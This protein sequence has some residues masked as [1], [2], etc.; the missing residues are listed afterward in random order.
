[1]KYS[2]RDNIMSEDS[3]IKKQ[4]VR[5]GSY[6]F[7]GFGFSQ[8]IRLISNIILT[9]LLFP[10]LFG[11]MALAQIVIQGVNLFSDLG[12]TKGLIRSKRNNEPDFINTA[13]TI[14]IIRGFVLTIVILILA[15]PISRFYNQK[16]LLY[17]I[18]ILSINSIIQSFSSTSLILLSK[19][20]KQGKLNL[21]ELGSQFIGSIFMISVA[22]FFKNIWSLII[23]VIITSIVKTIWSH[24]ITNTKNYLILEKD[25]ASELLGFGKWILISTSMTFMATQA[26]RIILGKIFTLS[27][28]GIYNVA[29]MFAELPKQLISKISHNLLFPL[30]TKYIHL[31]KNDLKK[32]IKRQRT[33]I[34]YPAAV[35]VAVMFCFG[36][37][38]ITFL[39]DDRYK[40]ASWMLQLLSIGM[41]P[42]L[43][44]SSI[45]NCLFALGKPEYS[46]Y[47]HIS[48]LIYMLVLLPLSYNFFGIPSS[49]IVIALNDIPVYLWINFGLHK[50]KLTIFMQDLLSSLFLIF[51]IILFF[52]FRLLL[53][54]TVPLFS[55]L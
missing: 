35:I 42:L 46:T 33:V 55:I 23:G 19:D 28:L 22:Y 48:K 25:A 2:F 18:P 13:W 10:E 49:I 34:L 44:H 54:L 50:E 30:I 37:Y 52:S 7:L 24:F 9:R 51:L 27:F 41:W 40:E 21:I 47:G 43:L 29:L 45:G 36:D 4:A 12:I 17:V 15:Y 39:Y 32:E 38:I 1:M 3:Q 20:L 53:G 6:I 14:Q 16:E 11:I 31:G 26:D 8:I 5:A